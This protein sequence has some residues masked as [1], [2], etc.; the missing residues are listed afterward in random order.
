MIAP[1]YNYLFVFLVISNAMNSF[2][3]VST[4]PALCS[5]TPTRPDET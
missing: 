4:K 5:S 1:V 2:D 3:G